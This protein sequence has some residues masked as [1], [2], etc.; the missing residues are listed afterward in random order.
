M[1]Y[2]SL[3]TVRVDEA[4]WMLAEGG[5][6]G[7]LVTTS[8]SEEQFAEIV[9]V[10]GDL[11]CVTVEQDTIAAPRE[12]KEEI[13]V[14]LLRIQT[15]GVGFEF[16]PEEVGEG[17]KATGQ[18]EVAEV[19]DRFADLYEEYRAH[20][21]DGLVVALA[22]SPPT[23][24]HDDSLVQVSRRQWRILAR[25][26]GRRT[27][28]DIRVALDDIDGD[29]VTE[30][31]ASLV[32]SGHLVSVSEGVPT[33]QGDAEPGVSVEASDAA[34]TPEPP[35]TADSQTDGLDG[36]LANELAAV[37]VAN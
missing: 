6:T 3:A 34:K 18:D 15:E 5:K 33:G 36:D 20:R 21:A 22:D 2:G 4:V 30:E 12:A 1:L 24:G 27:L 9:V 32:E 16:H 10:G 37:G 11:A 28:A 35:S 26:D 31:V 8:P 23:E 13:A 29:T 14:L 17:A 7:R 19:L 25:C